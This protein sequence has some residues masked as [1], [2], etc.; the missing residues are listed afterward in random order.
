MNRRSRSLA[1]H[2]LPR[3]E[4]FLKYLKPGALARLRDSRIS[5]RSHRTSSLFQISPSFPSSN[6]GQLSSSAAVDG[7]PCFVPTAR[8]YGPRCLQRRKLVAAKGMLFQSSSQ[9][10]LDLPDPVVDLLASE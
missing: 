8:V 5:A 6:G 1:R 2:S 10:A 4:P 3:S 7:F 9:S